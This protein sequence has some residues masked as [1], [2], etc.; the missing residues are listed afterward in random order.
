MSGRADD[1]FT[2]ARLYIE[3]LFAFTS[4]RPSTQLAKFRRPVV[5]SRFS[6]SLL[7]AHST[8][9]APSVLCSDSQACRLLRALC[10]LLRILEK[11]H[12]VSANA[13]GAFHLTS[14]SY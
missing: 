4:V 10:K 13:D 5:I 11:I 1:T 14:M 3:S 9:T 7:R 8:L 6:M 12:P 2:L